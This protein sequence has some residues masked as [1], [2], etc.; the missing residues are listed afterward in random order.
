MSFLLL[1]QDMLEQLVV[2]KLPNV[3]AVAKDPLTEEA[4]AEV[5]KVLLLMLGCAVQCERKEIFIERIKELELDVQQ[6]IVMHIQEVSI[7]LTNWILWNGHFYHIEVIDLPFHTI[8]FVSCFISLIDNTKK[9]FY[10][11]FTSKFGIMLFLQK[12]LHLDFF[13]FM[14]FSLADIQ[15]VTKF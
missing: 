5:L 10:W 13:K 14:L 6:E 7:Q 4:L 1:C 9:F 3:L 11:N 2:M 8:P 15:I 12:D